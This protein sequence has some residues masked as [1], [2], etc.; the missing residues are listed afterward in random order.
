M[1]KDKPLAP[2]KS[3]SSNNNS[4]NFNIPDDIDFNEWGNVESIPIFIQKCEVFNANL[5][6]AIAKID[7]I[8]MQKHSTM[9]DVEY[10]KNLEIDFRI[11]SF[12]PIGRKINKK[13]SDSYDNLDLGTFFNLLKFAL[14][15][16]R[17]FSLKKKRK[18]VYYYPDKE[19]ELNDEKRLLYKNLITKYLNESIVSY[20]NFF[21]N[22]KT[23]KWDVKKD[24]F[25]SIIILNV[26]GYKFLNEFFEELYLFYICLPF[27]I[28]DDYTPKSFGFGFKERRSV[29]ENEPDLLKRKEIYAEG[30]AQLEMSVLGTEGRYFAFNMKEYPEEILMYRKA[31][32]VLEERIKHSTASEVSKIE[33]NQEQ[34]EKIS[35]STIDDFLNDKTNI[36]LFQEIQNNFK[37]FE[38]KRLAILIYLL[39]EENKIILIIS[40]SNTH[41]RK[42]FIKLFKED[43]SFDKFQ[44]VNKY[45]D[46]FTNKL[47]LPT[48]KESDADYIN[49]KEKLTKLLENPV[50]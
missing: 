46:P 20:C 40:N 24:E 9:E 17:I 27:H 49:I 47:N 42:H 26:E 12:V 10:L 8:F 5:L 36:K 38:G 48:L 50:A 14:R 45:I 35:I 30:M 6:K 15:F 4:E 13:E 22:Q 28:L 43:T 3:E 33:K 25:R 7:H 37:H 1:K 16:L 44:A 18:P 39:Q 32:D 2:L 34:S 31:I 29:A 41:S 19:V 21:E 11:F 23:Y